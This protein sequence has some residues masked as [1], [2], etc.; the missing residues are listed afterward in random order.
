MRV[1]KH[2]CDLSDLGVFLI[3]VLLLNKSNRARFPCFAEPLNTRSTGRFSKAMQTRDVVESHCLE[4][5]QP[6]SWLNEVE[7]QKTCSIA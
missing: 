4:F 2:G 5:S 3:I 1:I 6:S 7:T